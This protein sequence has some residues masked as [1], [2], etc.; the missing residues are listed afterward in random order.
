M[1]TAEVYADWRWLDFSKGAC[2]GVKI[3]VDLAT[4]ANSTNI[5]VI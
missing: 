1:F 2:V 5:H 4:M 3:K